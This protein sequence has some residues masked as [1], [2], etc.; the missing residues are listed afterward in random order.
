MLTAWDRTTLGEH[1]LLSEALSLLLRHRSLQEEFLASELRGYGNLSM[2]VSVDPPV[3]V[4][5]LWNALSVPLRPALYLNS[6]V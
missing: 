4:G 2:T 1:H 5:S 3:E 6:T